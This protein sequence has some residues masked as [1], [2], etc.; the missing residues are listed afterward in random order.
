[1]H[2]YDWQSNRVKVKF[3]VPRA[4]IFPQTPAR[5]KRHLSPHDMATELYTLRYA[6]MTLVQ[7]TFS[8]RTSYILRVVQAAMGF[9]V[10]QGA[11]RQALNHVQLCFEYPSG[12]RWSW[13][14]VARIVQGVRRGEKQQR[15]SIRPGERARTRTRME[16]SRDWRCGMM[17]RWPSPSEWRD[18]TGALCRG[19]GDVRYA[20]LSPFRSRSHNTDSSLPSSPGLVKNTPWMGRWQ[21]PHHH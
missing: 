17:W 1:M 13:Q 5:R 18:E 19:G 2:S 9:R 16:G 14:P 10:V 6:P 3:F 15:T 4:Y 8:T 12:I 21:E 20:S 7:H 11:S